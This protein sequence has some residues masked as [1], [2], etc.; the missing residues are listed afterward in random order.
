MDA[1]ESSHVV[2]LPIYAINEKVTAEPAVFCSAEELLKVIADVNLAGKSGNYV[3]Q[4]ATA[5][6]PS[7]SDDYIFDTTDQNKILQALKAENFVGKVKDKSKGAAKRKTQGLPDEYLYV[8]KY[9]C[10]LKRRD[11]ITTN[12]ALTENLII[13]IKVNDR[14]VPY[15]KLF[16][17]SFHK[18]RPKE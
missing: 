7:L 11:A 8:F 12:D 3:P 17:V 13:Y 15:R 1:L 5:E 14:Q 16:V 9:P 6:N 10:K 4:T 18:N 2:P